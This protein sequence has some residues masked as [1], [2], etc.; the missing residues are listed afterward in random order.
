MATW[1]LGIGGHARALSVL[2]QGTMTDE[3]PTLGKDDWVIIGVGDVPTR[4][5]LWEMYKDRV[6]GIPVSFS[7]STQIMHKAF[8]CETAKLGENVL[9]NTGV[10][11]DHDC[12]I[13]D[14][15][16]VSPGAVLCGGVTLGE[17]CYISAGAVILQN[18][19]LD[20]ETYVPPGAVV[21][22]QDDIR[23]PYR[24]VPHLGTVKA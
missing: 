3:N 14:H 23:I 4:R 15:C 5:K 19:R 16:V 1:I 10:Q 13:G 20:D 8:V 22:G 18:V 24:K 6:V 12:K 17:M 9:V 7:R 11:I 2:C 21:Y